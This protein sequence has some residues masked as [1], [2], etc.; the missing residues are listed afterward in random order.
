M[1]GNDASALLGMAD[2]VKRFPGVVALAGVD[3][4]VRAG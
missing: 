4:D 3:L 1:A 2:I